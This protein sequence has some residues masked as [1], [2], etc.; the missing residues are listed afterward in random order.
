MSGL[1][2]KTS[3][4]GSGDRIHE[5]CEGYV[6]QK[7]IIP[8]EETVVC[9]SGFPSV[10]QANE[11]MCGPAVVQSMFSFY[12]VFVF[13]HDLVQ[14]LKTTEERGTDIVKIH[15]AFKTH[16]FRIKKGSFTLK[17]VKRFIDRNIPVILEI[18]AW[19]EEETDY[20]T[21]YSNDH[22]VVAI[23]YDETGIIFEDP[24]IA[25]KGHIEFEDLEN[26]WHCQYQSR[27][28]RGEHFG[29][30]VLGKKPKFDYTMIVPIK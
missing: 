25:H 27:A 22:F 9:V 26:R 7:T 10:I 6:K 24:Y 30:A 15:K 1:K 13:Q 3:Q 5:R 12:G 18:Q 21:T 16:N 28:K 23:G 19:A 20:S 14:E 4:I 11:W 2:Q 8:M 29:V 17:Q